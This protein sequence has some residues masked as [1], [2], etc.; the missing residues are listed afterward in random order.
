MNESDAR[1]ARSTGNFS[2]ASELESMARSL[3]SEASSLE[4]KGESLMKNNS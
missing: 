1:R 3:R 4:S 2:K